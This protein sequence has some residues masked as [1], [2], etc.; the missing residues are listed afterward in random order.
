MTEP[1]RF[2][3]IHEYNL[4]IHEMYLNQVVYKPGEFLYGGITKNPIWIINTEGIVLI[5][6]DLDCLIKLSKSKYQ[7]IID[8]ETTHNESI[9][10][11]YE[12]GYI[13]GKIGNNNSAQALLV[14]QKSLFPNKYMRRR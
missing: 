1:S 11:Y 12:N 7:H 5:Y 10:W 6:C 2:E 9:L 8:F 13:K 4:S 3:L 14:L